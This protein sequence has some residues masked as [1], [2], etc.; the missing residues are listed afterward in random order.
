MTHLTFDQLSVLAERDAAD[1]PDAHDTESRAHLGECGDCRETLRRV[2]ELL[3]VARALPRAMEPPPEVWAR[4][5]DLVAVE[6]HYRA[7]A[8]RWWRRPGLWVA[9]A[10]GFLLAVIQIPLWMGGV[11]Q[12]GKAISPPPGAATPVSMAVASV[13]RNY[14]TT[15]LQLREVLASERL[16]PQTRAVLERSLTTIDAAIAEARAALAADPANAA[17]VDILSAHYEKKIDL[18][19]RAAELSPSL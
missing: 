14:A 3:D 11:A 7:G 6:R 16:S 9:A 8:R 17:I 1:A 4:V 12:K 5:N 18:L 15:I 2:R 10:A 19:Q 13:D